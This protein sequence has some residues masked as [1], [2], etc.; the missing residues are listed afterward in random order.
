MSDTTFFHSIRYLPILAISF[1]TDTHS[2][3]DTY[4]YISRFARFARG[5]EFI[6]VFKLVSTWEHRDYKYLESLCMRR[7]EKKFHSAGKIKKKWN[8]QYGTTDKTLQDSCIGIENADTFSRYRKYQYFSQYRYLILI[9]A[10]LCY[11]Y[12]QVSSLYSW[13][14]YVSRISLLQ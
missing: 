10:N 9:S 3:T 6:V 4:V 14:N 13:R 8:T 5:A 1:D 2:D 11:I 7:H 12:L